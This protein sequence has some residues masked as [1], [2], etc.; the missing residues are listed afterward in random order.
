M[1][2]IMYLCVYVEKKKLLKNFNLKKEP[3]LYRNS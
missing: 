3:I 1:H 2:D